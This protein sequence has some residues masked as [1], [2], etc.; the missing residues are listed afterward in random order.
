MCVFCV[1]GN[2]QL[3][4]VTGSSRI[5]ML[6][7][8]PT[9]FSFVLLILIALCTPM[10]VPWGRGRSVH[11]FPSPK[12]WFHALCRRLVLYTGPS[13]LLVLLVLL[14]HPLE[15][16][17]PMLKRSSCKNIPAAWPDSQLLLVFL[18]LFNLF[19]YSVQ[20][21]KSCSRTMQW[22]CRMQHWH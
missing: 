12:S 8:P 17:W 10:V 5:R 22:L 3:A 15:N 13:I 9:L 18:V 16:P 19:T 4:V 2:Q 21:F 1:C 7:T 11:T 14:S 20:I 6:N